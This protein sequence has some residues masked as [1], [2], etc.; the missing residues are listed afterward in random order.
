MTTRGKWGPA[1]L[2]GLPVKSHYTPGRLAELRDARFRWLID[3][4]YKH[5][6]FYCQLMDRRGVKP[7]SIDGLGDIERLPLV[8]KNMLQLAGDSAWAS[9]L[10]ADKRRLASTS[11]STGQPLTLAFS[12]K[13]LLFSHAHNLQCMADIGWRPWHRG[14]A[15]GSQALP[16]GHLLER[17]GLCRW[18]RID[19]TQAVVKWLEQ[20]H[21]LRPQALHCYPSALREFCFEA[22]KQGGLDWL[23]GVLSVGGEMYDETITP[24]ALQVFG[25]RPVAM[26]GSVEAGRMAVECRE[27]R[28]YHVRLDALHLEILD[29]EQPV[30]PGQ[31]GT[32][33]ITSLINENIPIFRYELGDV[34]EWVEGDCPCGS[35]WPRIRLH[36]GR[37]SDV[38]PLPGG[39][40]VPVTELCAVAGNCSAIRQFQFILRTE[41]ELVLRYEPVEGDQGVDLV[42]SQLELMLPGVDIVL[43]KTG[44]LP[45]TASG[46]IKRL[47]DET[48]AKPGAH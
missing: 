40:Q 17:F 3:R 25:Q 5:N 13:D 23:P 32:V 35:Q 30:E 39:R 41:M 47:I 20:Y 22:Q 27:A 15:L 19:T 9:D 44:Q 4:A 1:W 38:I 21:Q 10:P 42:R 37:A 11:G 12:V 7:G 45:R 28:G 31:A 29:G 24:L 16:E 48:S 6:P 8:S 43:E 26:Y 36:Q 18:P 46:K 33:Y 14:Q 34:A 2:A